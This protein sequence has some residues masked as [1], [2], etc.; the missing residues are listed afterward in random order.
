MEGKNQSQGGKSTSTRVTERVEKGRL[1]SNSITLARRQEKRGGEEETYCL[2]YGCKL[3]YNNKTYVGGVAIDQHLGVV[4]N[5]NGEMKELSSTAA[6][7]AAS[8]EED[9]DEGSEDEDNVDPESWNGERRYYLGYAIRCN[10]HMGSGFSCMC[11]FSTHS[12]LEGL[13]LN[14]RKNVCVCGAGSTV[15]IKQTRSHHRFLCSPKCVE[16]HNEILGGEDITPVD[17]Y[18]FVEYDG[19]ITTIFAGGRSYRNSE[20]ASNV[21]DLV[22]AADN[23][24]L[25]FRFTLRWKLQSDGWPLL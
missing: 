6:D 1:T 14:K 12:D 4:P 22:G 7:A 11:H 2:K 18:R 3:E 13:P 23:D 25:P 9:D 19:K 21:F 15:N 24:A 20:S 17:D 16:K 5:G 8:V 10:E